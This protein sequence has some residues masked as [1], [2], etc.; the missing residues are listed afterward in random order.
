ME[1]DGAKSRGRAEGV[2]GEMAASMFMLT[3]HALLQH[4]AAHHTR[5]TRSDIPHMPHAE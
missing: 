4:D 3:L 2:W 5:H 1:G